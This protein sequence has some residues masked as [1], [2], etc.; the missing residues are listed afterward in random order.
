MLARYEPD[1]LIVAPIERRGALPMQGLLRR[2]LAGLRIDEAAV[3]FERLTG[4]LPIE[5]LNPSGLLFSDG[6]RRGRFYEATV[7]TLS[8][9]LA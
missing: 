5:S 4:K 1:W 9:G 3:A 7:R 8:M 2:R 6:F